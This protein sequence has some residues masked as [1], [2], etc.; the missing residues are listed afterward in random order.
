M[1]LLNALQ[2][3]C[4]RKRYWM[5]MLVLLGITCGI[6]VPQVILYDHI[7]ETLF[8]VLLTIDLFY[9]VIVIVM[10]VFMTRR[11]LNDAGVSPDIFTLL[12]VLISVILWI[13]HRFDLDNIGYAFGGMVFLYIMICCLKKSKGQ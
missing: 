8:R 6:F 13:S 10:F 4:G 12:V 11:R 1:D 9:F 7:S 3:R 2:G 5:T